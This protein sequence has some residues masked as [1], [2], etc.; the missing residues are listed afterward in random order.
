MNHVTVHAQGADRLPN[1]LNMSIQYVE[2]ESLISALSDEIAISSGSAC[3]S[4]DPQ[5]SYV[6]RSLGV[7][8]ELLH[9]SVRFGLGRFTTCEEIDYVIKRVVCEVEKLRKLSP[10]YRDIMNQK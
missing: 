9:T 8:G 6:L 2:S 7:R 5:S 4:E 10:I 1:N 3:S